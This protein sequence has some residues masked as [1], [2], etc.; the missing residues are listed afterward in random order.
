M[1]SLEASPTPQGTGRVSLR[2]KKLREQAGL[3]QQQLA[4]RAGISYFTIAKIEQ[5]NTKNPST[6]VL[7][8]L[9]TALGFDIDEFLGKSVKASLRKPK[10]KFVYSD[11]GGVLVHTESAFFQHLAILY[12]RPID[13]IRAVYHT[14]VPYACIGRL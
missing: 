9:S 10:I 8:K 2:L 6:T 11:I 12:D 13:R 3:T 7:Y 4:N 1:G 14:Y 5:G